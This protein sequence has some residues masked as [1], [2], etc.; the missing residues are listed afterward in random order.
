[1]GTTRIGRILDEVG[2]RQRPLRQAPPPH[3]CQR[4]ITNETRQKIAAMRITL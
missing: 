1:M 2:A 4:L 3:A